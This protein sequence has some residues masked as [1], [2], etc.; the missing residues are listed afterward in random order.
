[1][2]EFARAYIYSPYTDKGVFSLALDIGKLFK[3]SNDK[4]LDELQKHFY[5]KEISIGENPAEALE[6]A[7]A[8][9]IPVPGV[10]KNGVLM[11]MMEKYA[12]KCN[13]FLID[14]KLAVGIKYTK[15]SM[16]IVEHL[17]NIGYVLFHPRKDEGQHLY[18]IE[19]NPEIKS[20]NELDANVYRNIKTT[21]MYVLVNLIPQELDS[22]ALHSSNKHYASCELRYDAQ[23][24]TLEELM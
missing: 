1:M 6:E 23:Y 24:A 12:D 3:E 20:A 14:G 18:A 19:G 2:K 15:D 5:I 9:S 8:Q 4:L 21:G 7:K 22:S 11:V 16:E 13:K 10:Q 17:S